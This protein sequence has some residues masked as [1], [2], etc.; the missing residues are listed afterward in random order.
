MKFHEYEPI[1]VSARRVAKK[2]GVSPPDRETLAKLLEAQEQVSRGGREAEPRNLDESL[3]ALHWQFDST[4][5]E[6][7][8]PYYSV[9]PSLIK[10]LTKIDLSKVSS[11]QMVLPQGLTSLSIRLPQGHEIG[12]EVRSVWIHQNS[13]YVDDKYVPGIA[14]GIDHGEISEGTPVYLMRTFPQSDLSIED[15][16]EDLPKSAREHQGKQLS[17]DHNLAAIRLACTVCLMGNDS[18][19]LSPEVLSKDADRACDQNIELLVEKARRR[20]KVGWTLGKNMETIPHYRRPH[21]FL[22]WTGTGKK[23]PKIVMRSGSIVHRKAVEAVPTGFHS[24]EQ[25]QHP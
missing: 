1:I 4:W 10:M 23:I 22:A 2:M 21:P 5:V 24:D 15:E 11:K 6:E 7:R 13:L 20:G 9:Y 18:D 19:I 16:L 12:G 25:C 14:L 17:F 8:R 3:T